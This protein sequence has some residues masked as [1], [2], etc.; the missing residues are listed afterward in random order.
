MLQLRVFYAMK[1]GRT[2]T[3]INIFM[4]ATKVVLV[5][6]GEQTLHGNAAVIA[7]NV[8]TSGSY[9]V[10][11]LIGHYLLRRRMGGLGFRAVGGAVVRIGLASLV[12]GLAAYALVYACIQA[13]GHGRGG[14]LAGLASGTVVG[15][16]VMGVIAWQLRIPEIRQLAGRLRR[17]SAST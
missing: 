14:A 13:L 8:S 10:G 12:G 9:V 2:P 1:D 17:E 16:A 6:I 5:I 4:V 11:A 15:L 7:L 3:L